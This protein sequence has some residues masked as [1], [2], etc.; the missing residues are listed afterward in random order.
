MCL[1][2]VCSRSWSV[3]EVVSVPYVGVVVAVTVL[4][5]LLLVMHLSMVRECEGARVTEMLV[6]G[7]G[8]CGCGEYRT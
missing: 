6:L 7:W 4:R 1:C 2:G 5:V 3:W 8:R